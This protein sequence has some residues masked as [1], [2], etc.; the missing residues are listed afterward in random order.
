MCFVYDYYNLFYVFSSVEIVI[1]MSCLYRF[2]VNLINLGEALG[3]LFFVFF[4]VDGI[5]LINIKSGIKL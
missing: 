1:F 4:E 5:L 3:K 2:Y